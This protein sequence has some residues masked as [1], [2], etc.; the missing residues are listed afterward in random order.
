MRWAVTPN[1]AGKVGTEREVLR[2]S[3]PQLKYHIN[4]LKASVCSLKENLSSCNYRAEITEN[5][6]QN[7]ILQL[8][9]L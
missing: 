8:A 3:N 2:D 9:E 6:T 4:D 1:V 5:Q 7:L